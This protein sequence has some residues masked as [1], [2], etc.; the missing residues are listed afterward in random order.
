MRQRLQAL[1]SQDQKYTEIGKSTDHEFRNQWFHNW[2]G[3]LCAIDWRV[4]VVSFSYDIDFKALK[5]K[6]RDNILRNTLF[7]FICDI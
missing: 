7:I 4:Q 3:V 2:V 1:E 5:P 6:N